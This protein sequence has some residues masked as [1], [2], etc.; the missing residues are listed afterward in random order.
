MNDNHNQASDGGQ[1]GPR[2]LIFTAGVPCPCAVAS[3]EPPLHR[4]E[5]RFFADR[6]TVEI[7]HEDLPVEA[8]G[9]NIVERHCGAPSNAVHAHAGE[10]SDGR[11]KRRSIWSEL[12][13]P[14][15]DALDDA[16]LR[17]RHPVLPAPK[18]ATKIVEATHQGGFEFLVVGDRPAKQRESR[19]SLFSSNAA[20]A[21]CNWFEPFMFSV[22]YM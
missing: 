18:V 7:H 2:V 14:A 8:R 19:L 16:G 22:S 10:A 5:V 9:P 15:T 12:D 11:R 20:Q 1:M 21:G 6:T 3:R 13:H 4:W 17:A